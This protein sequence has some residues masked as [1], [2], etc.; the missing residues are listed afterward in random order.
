MFEYEQLKLLSLKI[1]LF[2]T[3]LS[4]SVATQDILFLLF[5]QAIN[6]NYLFNEGN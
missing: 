4:W 3:N 1:S 2:W 6:H 5:R